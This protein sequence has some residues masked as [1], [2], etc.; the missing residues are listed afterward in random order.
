MLILYQKTGKI[1]KIYKNDETLPKNWKSYHKMKIIPV[2]FRQF[3]PIFR[4][5]QRQNASFGN[6]LQKTNFLDLNL[7]SIHKKSVSC[8]PNGSRDMTI[9]VENKFYTFKLRSTHNKEQF[10]TNEDSIY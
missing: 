4:R 8:S 2:D 7:G 3:P 9:S 6:I 1:P 5:P 10:E